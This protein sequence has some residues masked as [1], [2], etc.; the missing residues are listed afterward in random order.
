M[1][2]LV[3]K[4]EAAMPALLT[5]K[6][7]ANYDD[8]YKG[9]VKVAYF[10]Y[11]KNG[12]TTDWMRVAA[13]AAGKNKGMYFLP[14][15]GDEVLVAFIND[16]INNPCVVGALWN[17]ADEFPE[18]AVNKDNNV[19]LIVTKSGVKISI[20]DEK[21]KESVKITTPKNA[22]ISICDEQNT[23]TI[24]DGSKKN[25]LIINGDNGSIEIRSDSK[26]MLVS[27]EIEIK[28]DKKV[29]I[30]SKDL[31]INANSELK[32]DGTQVNIG[33]KGNAKLTASGI[34]EI[35]GSMVKING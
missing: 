35:K 8:D 22:E 2:F 13:P 17:K 27:K 1:S 32:I 30:S 4:N 21:D 34:A 12:N 23:I 6:V 18:N 28:A 14:E 7:V 10:S 9:M 29:S 11:I 15:V 24:T 19:K 3:T 20:S 16:D 26:L 25:K 33:A 31:N 5:G